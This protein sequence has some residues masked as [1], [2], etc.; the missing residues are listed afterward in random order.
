MEKYIYNFFNK[1]KG[2]ISVFLVIVLVP[3]VTCC[4]LY[5]D[6]S[7][8]KLAQAVIES[9]ADLALNT[10]LSNFDLDL[11]EIYGLM[12]SAQNDDDIKKTAKDYFKKSMVSQGLESSYADEFSQ[13]LSGL[14]TGESFDIV[15][16]LLGIATSKDVEIS[17]VE[18]GNLANPTLMKQQI[19]EFMKYRGPIEGVSELWDKFS[20]IKNNIDDSKEI[21]KLTEDAN[22]YYEHESD[23]LKA[24]EKA[25]KNLLD[26]NDIHNNTPGTLH[27]SAGI[28]S[29]YI[30][31]IKDRITK[32][33]N[34][35]VY[36]NYKK[37]HRYYVMDLCTYTTY[38]MGAFTKP[39][40]KT[41]DQVIINV[42]NKISLNQ[43][44]TK[45]DGL[46]TAYRGY[47]TYARK[48]NNLNIAMPYKSGTTYDTQYWIQMQY[49]LQ[50]SKNDYLLSQF[51]K[52]YD[53]NNSN[54][55]A[56]KIAD[57]EANAAKFDSDEL[58]VTAILPYDGDNSHEMSY[59][60]CISDFGLL[61][62]KEYPN[63]TFH[64]I[65]NNVS[66]FCS[67]N[68]SALDKEKNEIINGVDSVQ[69]ELNQYM[70]D[71]TLGKS[72]LSVAFKYLDDAKN[73][74]E[75]MN[76]SFET[77]KADY[78]ASNS[79]VKN[80]EE[81]KEQY[82][83]AE[84]DIKNL[85]LTSE[86]IEAFKT[87]INNVK[88]L[89]GAVDS[90]IN[91]FKYKDKK[92]SDIKTFD[93][94]ANASQ[95]KTSDISTVKSELEQ[96]A[97]NTFSITIPNV[98]NCGVTNNNN[99]N[100]TVSQPEVYTWMMKKFEKDPR[101]EDANR[102]EKEKEYDKKK[103]KEEGSTDNIKTDGKT[104]NNKEIKNLKDLPSAK[105]ETDSGVKVKVSG[106]KN[107]S[108]MANAVGNL[109]KDI[110]DSLIEARD[111]LYVL[112][113][114]SNM[115]TYDTF[116]EEKDY[117]KK[118]N[119]GNED[120]YAR[121]TLTN[122]PMNSDN[123]YAY[124]SEIEYIIY[125][126]SNSA[127]KTAAYGT[128]YA[129]RYALDLV[130]AL[131]KFWG[132][133]TNTGKAINAFANGIA[134]ATSG[135]I[136]APLTKLIVILALTGME[137]AS[138]LQILRDGNPLALIKDDKVWL[139]KFSSSGNFSS[140]KLDDIKKEN[141][142]ADITFKYSDYLKLILMMKLISNDTPILKRTADVIQAN[143][144][145]KTSGFK[146]SNCNVYYQL[147][148]ECKTS[149][150]MLALPVVQGSIKE[151]NIEF[152]TW[153]ECSITMYRGY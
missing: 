69:K 44:K 76:T 62:R 65:V 71:M 6:S 124:G 140:N 122:Q 30:K 43:L 95:I 68:K 42:T 88:S 34:G 37:W 141:E 80:K 144:S 89:L 126:N 148:A 97:E 55:I 13:V 137:A 79:R 117:E 136:P 109:F 67:E 102:K 82:Q 15:N 24:L 143:M 147:T 106:K 121:C 99:P 123:N 86:K 104:N 115:F 98:S 153:N 105:K 25:Y 103:K 119:G 56:H 150:M 74:I 10:V 59:N 128:I 101:V 4:C 26:Y 64:A 113:Y 81:I 12:A 120:K 130:Y 139:H 90:A 151:S 114:I 28:N 94:F 127:N 3:I 78:D 132:T 40:I 18:N 19:V 50:S 14:L 107:I 5:V 84:N 135:V 72:Y 17:A 20:E 116:E 131:T 87:R 118:K 134:A 29:D 35:S 38:N 112:L 53:G 8:I 75:K 70:S 96:K 7:R 54:S 16:D 32:Q 57:I 45:I 111:D 27:I 100:F 41:P 47:E 92:I 58:D 63:T 146:M 2:V 133:G 149:I 46:Q 110:G 145:M 1:T 60:R 77:W 9:S 51:L 125:G 61:V 108:N 91:G 138:D 129:I 66:K 142:E 22:E 23:A 73:A 93:N 39:T 85:G 11:A 33:D 31:K 48:L 152:K 21:A 52:R 83:E 36:S 49:E